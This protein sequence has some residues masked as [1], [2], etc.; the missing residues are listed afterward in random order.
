MSLLGE[1]KMATLKRLEK[2][3]N[4]VKAGSKTS[5]KGQ[6]LHKPWTI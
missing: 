3:M 4:D 5:T 1:R 6:D 2:R